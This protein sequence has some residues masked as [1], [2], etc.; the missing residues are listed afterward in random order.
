MKVGFRH[1]LV[2]HHRFRIQFSMHAASIPAILEALDAADRCLD[3]RCMSACPQAVSLVLLTLGFVS[4]L[5]VLHSSTP[6]TPE[7][8]AAAFTL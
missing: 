4:D 8:V 1:F 7:H 5:P 6:S 2:S 3:D